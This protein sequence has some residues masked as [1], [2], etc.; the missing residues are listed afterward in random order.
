MFFFNNP[1]DKCL[2]K[3]P[4]L[5]TISPTTSSFGADCWYLNCDTAWSKAGCSNNLPLPFGNP[6]NRPEYGSWL[7]CCK[8]AYAG[9]MSGNCL[10][11]LL[12]PPTTSSTES[13]AADFLYPDYDT[14]WSKGPASAIVC[15]PFWTRRPSRVRQHDHLLT[16]R[17]RQ[18]GERRVLGRAHRAFH[19]DPRGFRGVGPHRLDRGRSRPYL[20]RVGAHPLPPGRPAYSPRRRNVWLHMQR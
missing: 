9:Q 13:G 18:A 8:A 17:V 19:P 1:T 20:M 7:E 16:G 10:G 15:R 4:S 11:D 2:S 5:P 14:A 12:S 3:I 6:A